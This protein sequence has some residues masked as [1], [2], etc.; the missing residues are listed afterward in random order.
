MRATVVEEI[1]TSD[2]DHRTLKL[3]KSKWHADE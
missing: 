2:P 1:E 3:Q